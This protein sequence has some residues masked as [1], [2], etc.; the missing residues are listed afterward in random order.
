MHEHV[1]LTFTLFVFSLST[2]FSSHYD[3]SN[4][5][6][7][8]Q[9]QDVSTTTPIILRKYMG[10][11]TWLE[12]IWSNVKMINLRQLGSD[13]R[14]TIKLL[15]RLY[16]IIPTRE[17]W[18]HLRALKAILFMLMLRIGWMNKWDRFKDTCKWYE[19]A[20][21]WETICACLC[22]VN[23]EKYWINNENEF[24]C[25]V[26]LK[27]QINSFKPSSGIVQIRLFKGVMFFQMLV[28]CQNKMH[29]HHYRFREFTVSVE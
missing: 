26:Y 8:I 5:D 27:L 19:I 4:A 28:W 10:K 25:K 16:S 17:S 9:H 29:V 14:H 11:M 23:S 1:K 18:R 24:N 7:S 12:K 13:W 20:I 21:S 22:V 2:R 6:G 3:A 15:L